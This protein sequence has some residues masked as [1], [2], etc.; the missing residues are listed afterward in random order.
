MTQVD[1]KTA[2]LNGE[3]DEDVLVMSPCGV[4][5]YSASR[6]KVRKALYGLKQGHKAWYDKLVWDLRRAFNCT[7]IHAQDG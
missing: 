6:Y 4:P 2:F 5:G 7:R 3:L 1:V